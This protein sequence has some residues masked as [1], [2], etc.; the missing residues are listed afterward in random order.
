MRDLKKA[1]DELAKLEAQFEELSVQIARQKQ[2]IVHLSALSGADE[3]HSLFADMGLTEVCRLVL[4]MCAPQVTVPQIK[5]M[6]ANFGYN[7]D[8][9]SNPLAS[10]HAILKRLEKYGEVKAV[11]LP[12]GGVGYEQIRKGSMG[13]WQNKGKKFK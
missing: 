13:N 12:D 3:T 9:H 5:R 1:E 10:I 4:K 7:I 2:T 11:T 6:V 8:A